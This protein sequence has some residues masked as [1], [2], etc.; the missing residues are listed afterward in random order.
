MAVDRLGIASSE[1]ILSG[2]E[3]GE[4]T[5]QIEN[6]IST[7]SQGASQ[8]LHEIE[9]TS[10]IIERVMTAAKQI[11]NDVIN[12]HSAAKEGYDSSEKGKH[13]VQNA[14]DDMNVISSF[15]TKL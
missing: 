9:S 6:A 1:M 7:L 13:L 10:A 5:D 8:Q 11:E 12:I 2:K 4:N 14:V 15:S 3:I